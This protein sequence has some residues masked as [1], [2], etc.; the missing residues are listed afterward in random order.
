MCIEQGFT[1]ET[2][3]FFKKEK[4]V[5]TANEGDPFKQLGLALSDSFYTILSGF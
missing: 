1:S 2:S 3:Y 4:Q 5:L